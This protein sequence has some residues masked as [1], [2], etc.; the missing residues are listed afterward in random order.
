VSR[1]QVGLKSNCLFVCHDLDRPEER[2]Q[3][4]ARLLD[5]GFRERAFERLNHRALA[6]SR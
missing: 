6:M 4:G 5:C 1:S 3:I 2:A